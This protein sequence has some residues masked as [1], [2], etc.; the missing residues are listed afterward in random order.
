[1]PVRLAL[2]LFLPGFFIAWGREGKPAVIFEPNS[3]QYRHTVHFFSRF[4]ETFLLLE[5]TGVRVVGAGSLFLEWLGGN[6]SAAVSGF[7]ETGGVS[8]YYRTAHKPDWRTGIRHYRRVRYAS[9]YPGV[10]LIFY[11]RGNQF[12]FDFILLPGADPSRI[13]MRVRGAANLWLTAAGDLVIKTRGNQ[14]RLGKPVLYQPGPS[15]EKP[16]E[17]SYV[18]LSKTTFRFHVGEYEPREPLVIDPTLVSTYI[19]G[20]DVDIPSAAATDGNGN[21]Y[22]TGYTSSTDFPRSATPYK[23]TLVSGD[24]DAFVMK[25]NPSATAVLYS[26]FLGG[27]FA[28]YGR[29]IAVDSA[30]AAYITGSTI[31][32]FPTTAGAF[33]ELP[34]NAPAI[35]SAKLDGAGGALVYA[36]YLDGAGAGQAIAVDSG[37]NAYIA[38]STYTPTFTTT[39]GAYQRNYGGGTDGFLVKLNPAGTAQ[40]YS[41]FLGGLSEDQIT[42]IKV[43]GSGNAYVTGFTTSNNFPATPSA[44]RT[45]YSGSTDAFVSKIKDDGSALLYSTYLGGSNIDRCYAIDV[46]GSG[47]AYIAGQT[48]SSSFPTTA[49]AFRTAHGGGSD[50]FVTKLNAAGSSLVY[51]TF[52]GGAGAC[53]VSDPFRQY[54]CDSAY[55]INVDAG[56][57]AYVAGLAGA[58]F[59]LAAASQ[60][61]PGGNGD[62][63]VTQINAAGT[64]LVYSSFLGGGGGD[65]ALAVVNSTA[66]GPVVAGFT[67]STDFP[68]TTGALQTTHGGG[69]QEGFLTRLASCP[70]TL[71]SSGSFFPGAAGSYSIDVFASLACGWSASSG[72]SWITVTNGIGAGNGQVFFDVGANP[73]GL[74]TGQISVNGAVYTVQQVTHCVT[75]GSSGSWFPQSGGSY[76]LAVFAT[77]AWT[78]T[79]NTSWIAITSGSGTGNG[80]V[81]YTVAANNTG[82]ARSG[83]IDVSGVIYQ[84][85][86]VG[87]PAGLS[88][89]VTLSKTSDQV[90]SSGGSSSLWVSTTAGCEWTTAHS[91]PWI[92][93]TAGLAGRGEGVL[94]YTVSPNRTGQARAGVVTIG[95]QTLTIS[96]AP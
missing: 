12:E 62:A 63:F 94:G 23:A 16:V 37:G 64:S 21:I 38:G 96:Q 72:E 35:F 6:R 11:A 92:T 57:Q 58:G 82:S 26:T 73:G 46:D 25:L 41:T 19:G 34:A 15:G 53:T 45:A 17:G 28:D 43:D 3:G 22:L 29:A 68:V 39:V 85:N 27:T 1:M 76:G 88:C 67:N 2:F 95:G 9:V 51:S 31:G 59:Q 91:V 20:R 44:Y 5:D 40:V 66:S 56:G 86:Q 89:A 42:G 71:G 69:A 74:R 77:C 90:H 4:A 33:R 14:L 8:N 49:G 13:R 80:Q 55:A 60:S 84:I 50:A 48:L 81:N 93:I 32:R 18:L 24:A 70:V 75:L 36:T 52:L 78:A 7:D 61:S 30:G 47:N 54:S 83:Q 87:G 79:S 65:V 10:D